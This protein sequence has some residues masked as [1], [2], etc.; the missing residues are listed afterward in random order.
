MNISN[1][2][3]TSGDVFGFKTKDGTY[4]EMISPKFSYKQLFKRAIQLKNKES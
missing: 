2:Q 3:H 4:H 1:L